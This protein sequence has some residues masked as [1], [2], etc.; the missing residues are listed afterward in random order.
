MR[1]S[2]AVAASPFLGILNYRANL[3][4]ADLARLI[5]EDPT[6]YQTEAT[7][8]LHAID[9]TLG[10]PA[11]GWYADSIDPPTASNLHPA[12]GL[13]TIYL[14]IGPDSH[15]PNPLPSPWQALHLYRYRYPP[16]PD[17]RHLGL[18]D[19]TLFPAQHN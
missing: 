16:Y 3:L 17:P 2:I 4:A 10:M 18:A 11:K 7:H 5:G 14:A 8:I 12:A 15:V 9:K 13:W 19:T 1:S 6:P